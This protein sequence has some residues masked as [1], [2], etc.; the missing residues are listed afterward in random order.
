VC[1]WG[2]TSSASVYMGCDIL[3]ECAH[4]VWHPL[5]VCTWGVASS[6]SVYM[7]CGI[8]CECAHGVWHPLRVCTWGVASS[9]SVHMG[10]GIIC[11]CAH[12][13][14]HPLRPVS[15]ALRKKSSTMF[16]PNVQST[17]L[18]MDCTTWRFWTMRQ[19]NGCST[20]APRS[21]APKQWFD[22]QAQQKKKTRPQHKIM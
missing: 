16:S 10:C 9:V 19:S 15:M 18:L 11:E 6:A 12:G 2:V 22:E 5:R 20:L 13:V 14:W 8:L 1:T 4:G 21:S 17:D 7:G 3:C